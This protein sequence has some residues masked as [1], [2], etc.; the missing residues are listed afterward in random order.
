[1]TIE[2]KADALALMIDLA[3]RHVE[4]SQESL[5][6]GS[7]IG[8]DWTDDDIRTEMPDQQSPEYDEYDFDLACEIRDFE[9]ALELLT[10]DLPKQA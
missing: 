7:A 8:A 3:S 10:P 4:N 5:S 6:F 9:R 1:M 2:T